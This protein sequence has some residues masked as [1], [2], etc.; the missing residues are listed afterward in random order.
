MKRRGFLAGT[1]AALATPTWAE[2]GQPTLIS[3]ANDAANTTFLIGLTAT[4]DLVFRI[5]V[6]GRGHAAAAHP[7]RAEA[8][9]FARR[10]GRFAVVIDCA[11]GAEKMRLEPPSGLHF[12]GHGAFTADGRLLLTT[13]NA[14]DLPDGRIGL[15]DVDAGYRRIGDLPSG[16]IGPHEIL[17]LSSGGFAVANGGI[18]THPD[19]DR[20]K[21][22]LPTMQPN[23]SLLDATGTLTH[24]FD[25]PPD[26][27][28]N[29]I[30]HICADPA[31]RVFIALQWQGLPTK[32]VPL[33]AV[34]D[35]ET[36][37]SYADHPAT[38]QL[39]HYAGSIALSGDRT[40]VA[41]TGPKGDHVLFWDAASGQ[42]AGDMA[43][44]EPSG[45]A[46][47]GDGLILTTRGGLQVLSGAGQTRVA[48]GA[49]L[50]WDNHLV[51]L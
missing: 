41:V 22:N 7:H 34:L 26:M 23:L 47:W 1:L 33:L 12:Y 16:G 6:P 43:L 31:G 30:R 48:T 49:G 35:P 20:A 29:S 10:P 37:L 9:A 51:A 42:P 32:S 2:I 36:G 17:R 13:E 38:A 19:Y 44:P 11:T 50:T 28:L 39:K 5:P 18:Q 27:R 24:S 8:V 4:G 21:L 14:F 15:W 40:R 3:A 25:A 46:P 45:V